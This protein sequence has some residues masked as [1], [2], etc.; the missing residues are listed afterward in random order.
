MLLSNRRQDPWAERIS[1]ANPASAWGS[2]DE[3]AT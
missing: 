2:V 3:K 1:A